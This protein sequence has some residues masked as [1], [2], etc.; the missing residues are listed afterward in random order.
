ML[1]ELVE[2]FTET[3]Y[4]ETIMGWEVIVPAIIS[5]AGVGV[6]AY[7]ASKKVPKPKVVGP[8]AIETDPTVAK[9]KDKKYRPAAQ[10]FNDKEFR[11]GQ[12][13]KLGRSVA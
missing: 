9:T 7:S 5:A 10:I 1:S 12:E 6:S 4:K 3:A 2:A 8:P 13:G 11:L